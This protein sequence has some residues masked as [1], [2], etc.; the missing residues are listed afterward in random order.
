MMRL[1]QL[2]V[3][4]LVLL[5][6]PL[7]RVGPLTTQLTT[8][9]QG[10]P[11]RGVWEC[12]VHSIKALSLGLGQVVPTLHGVSDIGQVFTH[13]RKVLVQHLKESAQINSTLAGVQSLSQLADQAL[14]EDRALLCM[15][16]NASSH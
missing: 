9:Q 11:C 4:L 10:H 12:V 6:E 15:T 14:S 2:A 1:R 5:D 3:L 16:Q 7:G 13:V 8:R